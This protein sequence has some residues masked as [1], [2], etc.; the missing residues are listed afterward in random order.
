MKF[1]TVLGLFV[2]AFFSCF[3]LNGQAIIFSENFDSFN[4]N[5]SIGSQSQ[6]L[7]P[8]MGVVNG[9]DDALISSLKYQSPSN[10]LRIMDHQDIYYDCGG[11]TSGNYSVEF[12]IYVLAGGSFNIQHELES[13]WARNVFLRDDEQIYYM[14]QPGFS[15]AFSVGT[16]E[17]SEWIKFR[18]DIDIDNDQIQFFKNDEL[19]HTAPFS[20]A[21][22]GTGNTNLDAVDFYGFHGNE[23]VA[24]SNFFVDDFSIVDNNGPTKVDEL[25]KN[26]A[27]IFPNPADSYV[28]ISSESNIESIELINSLG[29]TIE[30]TSLNSAV[31]H[32]FD[33]SEVKDGVYFLSVLLENGDE[34]LEKLIV[35]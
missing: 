29:Q 11:L 12:S 27:T 6:D 1:T 23:W 20:N 28:S 14:D 26:D 10:S 34:V 8:V 35:K 31:F 21:A 32:E 25:N 19:L 4:A 16:Y 7:Q 15:N 9:Y 3:S 5:E 17:K 24:I 33:L 30:K 18:F 2:A 22:V 13:V